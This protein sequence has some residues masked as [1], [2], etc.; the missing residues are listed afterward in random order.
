MCS[1]DTHC[2]RQRLRVCHH[3]CIH[4]KPPSSTRI[5]KLRLSEPQ[6]G[7][8]CH[9][10]CAPDGLTV[11]SLLPIMSRSIILNSELQEPHSS[12][13]IWEYSHSN[14]VF[15]LFTHPTSSRQQGARCQQV[16]GL[17]TVTQKVPRC[18]AWVFSLVHC[19]NHSVMLRGKE[20]DHVS[21]S[22]PNRWAGTI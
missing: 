14:F 16:A 12:L 20:G 4:Q 11:P 17:I 8:R 21:F 7:S 5:S 3:Q 15:K 22:R 6:Q 1:R 19:S 2:H 13:L 18:P 9:Q 10:K